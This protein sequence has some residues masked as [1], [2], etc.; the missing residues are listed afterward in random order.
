MR[1]PEVIPIAHVPDYRTSTIGRWQGGQFFASVTAAVPEDWNHDDWQSQKRWCAVLHQFDGTGRHLGSRIQFTGTTADGETKAIAAADQ[2]LAAWLNALP[3]RQYQDIA[4][5]P[6]SVQ[7]EGTLFGLV[8]ED[9]EDD[10]WA[11]FC[12]DGLGFCAPWDGYYDT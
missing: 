11:E 4:I 12:P 10:V 7:F 3:E 5:E 2:L 1:V 9:H 6:F 8:M